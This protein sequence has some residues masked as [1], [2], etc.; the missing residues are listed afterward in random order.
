MSWLS[1]R[2]RRVLLSLGQSRRHDVGTVLIHQGDTSRTEILLLRS[3]GIR[4]AS[5]A[6]VKVSAHLANGSEAMLGIRVSGDVVGE[7]ASLRRLPRSATVTACSPV[8]VHTILARDFLSFLDSS[9]PAWSALTRMVAERL[10]WANRRRLDMTGYDVPTRLA[11]VLVELADRHGRPAPTGRDIGV[12]LS[13]TELGRL[14]GAREDAVGKAV[15]RLKKAGLIQS[16]YRRYVINDVAGLSRY[17]R[18]QDGTS[19]D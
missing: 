1:P 19:S 8:L 16:G 2:D 18:G 14:V 3:A 4:P 12:E 6:C 10:D 17:A 5:T 11:R 15:Q 7:M 13:Q 9:P